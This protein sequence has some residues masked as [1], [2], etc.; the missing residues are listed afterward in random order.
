MAGMGM[1]RALV[2]SLALSFGLSAGLSFAVPA[3]AADRYDLPEDEAAAAFVRA[4]LISVFYHEVGHALIDVLDLAVLGREEDAADTLSALLINQFWEEEAAVEL[5]YHT[6]LSFLMFAELEETTGQGH[7]YWGQHSLDMQRYFSLV[8]LFYGANPDER[9]DVAV[10]L[11]LPEDRA[12]R[13]PEE[14]ESAEASWGAMLEGLPP[15]DN[16][17]RLRLVV[18]A[19]RDDYTAI[20]AEEIEALNG[21]YG[22]PVRVDVSVERCGEANAFYDPRARRVV[23][24]ID[25]AEELE[26]LHAALAP[27]DE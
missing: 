8:C 20:I 26:R 3:Q 19:D 11:G 2:L 5:V 7:A 10:E 21:E 17:P 16:G 6:A 27:Q 1:L 14:F 25:Y 15:Q 18:P 24:C 23:M 12:V 22:L 9:E 13:C 4:N